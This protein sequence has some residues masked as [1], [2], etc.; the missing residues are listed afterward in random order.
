VALSTTARSV[1]GI[2]A[3]A[4]FG[5][6]LKQ[7]AVEFNG[8]TA[9]DLP[10]YVEVCECT[11]ATNATPGTNNTSESGNIRQYYGRVL[12]NGMTAM[13]AWAATFEPTVLTVIDDFWLDPNKGL[14]LYD[15]LLGQ[16]PD[17]PLNEGF[18]LRMTAGTGTPSVRAKLKVERI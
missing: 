5:I 12:A 17:T 13:S 16:E 15:Y 8:V 1:L 2:R 14:I 10:V 9:S 4:A 11:F 18:V 7:Y 6:Q 3:G